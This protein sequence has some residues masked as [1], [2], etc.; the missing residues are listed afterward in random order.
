MLVFGFGDLREVAAMK[1]DA[2]RLIVINLSSVVKY[3]PRTGRKLIRH[4]VL[5]SEVMKNIGVME[6]RPV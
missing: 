5:M 2:M 6:S 4:P 1:R 3:P